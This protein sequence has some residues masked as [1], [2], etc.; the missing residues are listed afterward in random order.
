MRRYGGR[1]LGAVAFSVARTPDRPAVVDDHGVVT[2][3][4]LWQGAHALASGLAADG[5]EPGM[6]VG[7]LAQNSSFFVRSLLAAGLAG[8]DVVLLNTNFASPQLQGV[9]ADEELEAIISSELYT[10]IARSSGVKRV[11]DEDQCESYVAE[12]AGALVPPPP[13]AGRTTLL[14]SGTTGRPR[15]AARAPGG[16]LEGSAAILG[17]IPLRHGGVRLVSPPLFHGWGLTHLLLGLGMSSTVIVQER[18]D[19][20]EV[21]ATIGE[22]SV[23]TLVVVPVMLQRILDLPPEVLAAAKLDRMRVLACSGS[24]LPAAV[25]RET[26]RRFGP[27]LYNVYGS[28]EVAIASIATPADLRA[29]PATAGRPA[30]GVR[31]A[32]LDHAG[33]EVGRGHS[34]RVFVRGAMQFEGYTTG[35][36]KESVGGMMATG[37]LGRFD[38]EGRLHVVGREDDMIVSGAE[39]VYPRE[40]EDLLISHPDLIDVAVVGVDDDQ[41]GQVLAAYVVQRPGATIDHEQVKDFVRAQL[42]RHKVP[43]HVVVLPELPRNAM[44]KVLRRKL[45]MT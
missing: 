14:T 34:G 25:A 15:G 36:G 45:V 37:D 7:L 3:R 33:H 22:R 18:F 43:R 23:D 28:T 9:V 8:V 21:L 26:L 44:G 12:H 20:E 38:A 27:V 19:P 10:A 41:F 29:D 1:T 31:V 39:N 2:Y 32:L 4:E 42:A 40:I 35:G 17:R 13:K 16:E 30:P 11:L 5:L 6:R 24:A